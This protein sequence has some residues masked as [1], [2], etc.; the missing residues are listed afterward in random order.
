MREVA[1]YP[2]EAAAQVAR[3]YLRAQG[4][5]ARIADEATQALF[6]GAFGGF[7]LVVPDEEAFEARALLAEVDPAATERCGYA[8]AAPHPAAPGAPPWA[9]PALI[10]GLLAL[11]AVTGGR[12]P[13]GPA[14]PEEVAS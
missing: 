13:S 4:L 11:L 1:V 8:G 7:R 2:G 12:A 9:V 5:D 10:L 14:A 3:G 6:S